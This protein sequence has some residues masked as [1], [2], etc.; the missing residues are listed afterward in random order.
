[1]SNVTIYKRQGGAEQVIGN[2]GKLIMQTGS[3]I[4]PNSETQASHIANVTGGVTTSAAGNGQTS[5]NA[6]LAAMRGV[7]ILATS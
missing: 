6:I 7:G 1:M 5:I 3:A 2:G 4:V